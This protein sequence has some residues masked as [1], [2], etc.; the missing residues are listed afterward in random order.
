MAERV[1]ERLALLEG[2]VGFVAREVL[3]AGLARGSRLVGERRDG[4]FG[5]EEGECGEQGRQKQRGA[6]RGDA[7]QERRSQ[8]GVRHRPGPFGGIGSP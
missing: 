5:G 1:L 6:S 3:G 2:A 8:G 4:A 7:A